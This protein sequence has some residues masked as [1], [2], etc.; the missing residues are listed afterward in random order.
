MVELARFGDKK[1]AADLGFKRGQPI[2][3]AGCARLG[4][5]EHNRLDLRAMAGGKVGGRPFNRMGMP[6]GVAWCAYN[7]SSTGL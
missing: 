4:D 6:S 3:R 1:A 5:M 7:P 2:E